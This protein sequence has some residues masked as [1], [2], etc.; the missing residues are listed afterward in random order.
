MRYKTNAIII[1][2]VFV[3]QV[4]LG[5]QILQGA[6]LHSIVVADTKNSWAEK[7]LKHDFV[8]LREEFRKVAKYTRLEL[9]EVMFRGND[10]TPKKVL[11]R[12][13]QLKVEPDDVVLFCFS[14]L[15]YRTNEKQ[16]DNPWPNLFFPFSA[17]GIDY[18]YIGQVLE[19]LNPRLLLM[20]TCAS[21]DVI[22]GFLAP[23]VKRSPLF[24][25]GDDCVVRENYCKLF[26]GTTGAIMFAAAAP[27]EFAFFIPE[28]GSLST[29]AFL[30]ALQKE[31]ESQEEPSWQN[32]FENVTWQTHLFQQPVYELYLNEAH[33]TPE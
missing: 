9:N 18:A 12:L 26:L 22:S 33:G 1:A 15:G 31:T 21:N 16:L 24:K 28:K 5:S 20:M 17:V 4:S 3:L 25:K 10:V 29:Q 11:A 7:E 19:R 14:G 23:P 13:A 30:F 6:T 27:G 2:L 8:N 32:I